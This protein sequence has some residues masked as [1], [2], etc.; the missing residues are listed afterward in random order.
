MGRSSEAGDILLVW[1]TPST[2]KGCTPT[3][4]SAGPG[5]PAPIVR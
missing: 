5:G 3:Q 1:P 2:A 4:M